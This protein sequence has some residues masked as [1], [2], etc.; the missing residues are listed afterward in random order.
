MES[1]PETGV[2]APSDPV[3]GALEALCDLVR[4]IRRGRVAS[5]IPEIARADPDQFG[6]ALVSLVGH[7]YKAGDATVPI[8]LQSISKPFV[9]ALAL[10]DEGLDGM[11]ARVGAEPSG[12][13]FNAISLDPQSGR[14]ANPMINAGAIVTTSIVR[15]RNPTARFERIHRALS[16]FAGR[17]LDVD[18][19]VYRSELATGDRNR[20]LAYLMRNAGSLEGEVDEVLDVY[21]RQ[22]AVLVTAC[23][24]AV[25]AATLANGGRNP[26]TG[27]QVV[28]ETVAEQTCAVMTSCGMYDYAGE[29]LVRVGLPAKS[30]VTGGL[31]AVSPGQ[32]GVGMFS[33]PLDERGNSVRSVEASKVLA[34]RFSLQL[35]HRTSPTPPV[36]YL[37]LRRGEREGA[38]ATALGLQGDLDFTAAEIVLVVVDR[39]RREHPAIR[40][41]VMDLERVS[42][43]RLG[44][45]AMLGAMVR[46]LGGQGVEV[47]VADPLARSLVPDAPDAPSVAAAVERAVRGPDV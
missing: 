23:D 20:A 7:T 4:P 45:A 22:C 18:E 33:P 13:A 36:C 6:V 2:D 39:I 19:A 37:D 41:L 29:W 8:T 34:D 26:V 21:F 25:M 3:T 31:M 38:L 47:V 30:G 43:L 15:A 24:I 28:D 5:Y 1:W 35:V 32:F 17:E 12:E 11:L 46:D 16:A 10:A 14:P 42:R 40:W 27:E 44:A 9:F